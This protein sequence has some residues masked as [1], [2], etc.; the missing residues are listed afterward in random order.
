M[1][2]LRLRDCSPEVQ[3]EVS[4]LWSMLEQST[5]DNKRLRKGYAECIEDMADW[6]MY[7]LDSPSDYYLTKWN[8][9]GDIN[10]H[11]ENLNV[12]TN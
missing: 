11:K 12:H 1:Y 10:K 8:L 6:A 3:R 2:T 9:E 4:I 5:A 7:A